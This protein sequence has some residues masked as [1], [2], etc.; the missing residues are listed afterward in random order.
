MQVPGTSDNYH[1]QKFCSQTVKKPDTRAAEEKGSKVV[2]SALPSTAGRE[3]D[4]ARVGGIGNSRC[5]PRIG[6]DLISPPAVHLRNPS[7]G[8]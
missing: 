1:Y 2:D 8:G 7:A 4:T 5:F 3:I 6:T